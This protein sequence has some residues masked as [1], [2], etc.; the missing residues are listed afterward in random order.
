MV[1]AAGVRWE[2]LRTQQAPAW[3]HRQAL[4]NLED[5]GLNWELT[6]LLAAL[7][8]HVEPPGHDRHSAAAADA[9]RSAD[10]VPHVPWLSRARR[11]QAEPTESDLKDVGP[12]AGAV[13][14]HEQA[15]DPES[16][17]IDP[18]SYL[19]DPDSL[20]IDPES[21][22]LDPEFAKGCRPHL[23]I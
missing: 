17:A 3:L 5:E 13:G 4:A 21:L 20:V 6:S 1:A 23:T 9:A 8:L 2:G 15:A 22:A 14:H 12:P 7:P 18:E 16:L 11:S 10:E 19:T